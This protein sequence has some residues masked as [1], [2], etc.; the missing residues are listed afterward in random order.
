MVIRPAVRRKER[1]ANIFQRNWGRRETTPPE[2][3]Q[4][5]RMHSEAQE[6][7]TTKLKTKGGKPGLEKDKWSGIKNHRKKKG[8]EATFKHVEKSLEAGPGMCRQ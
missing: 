1:K 2:D 3:V 7:F 8:G 4:R 6:G 5:D